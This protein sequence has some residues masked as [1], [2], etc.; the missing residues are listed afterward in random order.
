MHRHW[1][2]LHLGA[3]AMLSLSSVQLQ[4]PP[5]PRAPTTNS[6]AQLVLLLS[7][8]VLFKDQNLNASISRPENCI[9]KWNLSTRRKMIALDPVFNMHLCQ[10]I[11]LHY[12]NN[13]NQALVKPGARGLH[14]VIRS[15]AW[16]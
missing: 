15:S 14:L 5:Q 6:C 7:L 8:W 13:K 4:T 2:Q 10:P 16:L 12:K 9:S 1:Q 11:S 3:A